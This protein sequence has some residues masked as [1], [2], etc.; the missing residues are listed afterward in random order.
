MKVPELFEE[1]LPRI[2]LKQ[3]LKEG[4]TDTRK[5]VSKMLKRIRSGNQVCLMKKALY[6]LKQ[7]GRQ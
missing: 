4:E 3:V 6:G 7:A 5:T 1:M 2:I